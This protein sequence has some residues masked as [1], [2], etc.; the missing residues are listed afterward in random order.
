MQEVGENVSVKVTCS[1]EGGTNKISFAQSSFPG[2]FHIFSDV[3]STLQPF[4]ST[5]ISFSSIQDLVIAILT[6]LKQ[7]RA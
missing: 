1:L 6:F 3:L 7:A 4:L 5:D 2:R